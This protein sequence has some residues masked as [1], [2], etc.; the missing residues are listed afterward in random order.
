MATLGNITFYADDPRALAHFWSGV[1]GYP[2]LEWE[3]PMKSELLAAGLTEADLATRALAED[4][5]GIGPRLFFHHADGPK[6]GRNRLH[7][8]VSVARDGDGD[9]R[10]RLETEKD[11]LVALGATVVRLV[12]QQW[13]P[14][15]DLYYQLRDP[16]GNEFCL[17]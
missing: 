6:R 3:E 2:A 10:S 15:P 5:E 9:H 12:D 11:R 7:L 13:G 4:P 14:W 16:E 8:D 17:Q 1:F